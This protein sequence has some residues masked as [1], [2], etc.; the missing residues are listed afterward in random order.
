MEE[1]IGTIEWMGMRIGMY[2]FVSIFAYIAVYI[3]LG[4]GVS[5]ASSTLS[6]VLM[7]T[8]GILGVIS[9]ALAYDARSRTDGSDV[10][11]KMTAGL[12]VTLSA[13]VVAH[14]AFAFTPLA[15]H[16]AQYP[17]SALTFGLIV[18]A[19]IGIARSGHH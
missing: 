4:L 13:L 3:V 1:K 10:V 19:I 14:M 8:W 17:A 11:L 9:L 18:L 16:C 5:S 2:S 6:N 12:I 15:R 7:A